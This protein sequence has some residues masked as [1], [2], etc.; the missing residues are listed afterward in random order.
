MKRK[1]YLTWDETFMQ[2]AKVVS[3]RSKDP[4]TQVGAVFVSKENRII[5]LGYNGAPSGFK[6]DDFP[7]GKESENPLENKYLFVVHAERNGV[8]NYRGSLS[9]F[10]G[11]SL[12]VTLFPCNECAKELAQL[13]IKEVVWADNPYEQNPEFQASEIILRNAGITNRK[14]SA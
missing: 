1:D 6:D 2:I 5:S 11:A 3:G 7:W 9:D 8:L 13:S 12:Y 10:S 4:S 14:F